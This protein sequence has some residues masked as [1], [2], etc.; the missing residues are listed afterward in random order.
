MDRTAGD[1]TE[2]WTHAILNPLQ[3]LE[4]W[5][6]R[7]QTALAL[8]AMDDATLKDIGVHRCD[9]RRLVRES[10]VNR[11]RRREAAPFG[12]DGST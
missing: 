3:M 2:G 4:R 9:I 1:E 8:G 5:L 10:D 7:R 12:D 11:F 6:H